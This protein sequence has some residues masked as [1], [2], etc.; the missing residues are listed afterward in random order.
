MLALL[1]PAKRLDLDPI[2][3]KLDHSMPELLEDSKRLVKVGRKLKSKDLMALMGISENLAD[4]NVQRFK[5]WKAPFHPENAKQAILSF[6]GDVYLGFDAATLDARGMRFAQDH[7]RIL[8]GLYGVLRP[9]DLIQPYRLEMGVR[10]PVNG[11]TGLYEFW[12]GRITDTLN[13]AL[14]AQKK[15]DRDRVVVN[16]ASHEYF[17]SVQPDRLEARLVSCAFKEVKGGKAKIVAFF[18]KRARGTMA[19]FICEERVTQ[20]DD[21]KGFRSG[22]YRYNAKASSDDTLVFQRKS[23]TA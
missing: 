23:T 10:L 5:D 16:L 17:G 9:L 13:A 7:L 11:S 8:S 14:G 4:L 19:R 15:R 1:S 12:G 3:R 6:N 18:A 21:L 22:G 20:V 2:S